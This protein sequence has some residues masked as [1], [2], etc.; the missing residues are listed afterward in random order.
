MPLFCKS[1]PYKIISL[2]EAMICDKCSLRDQ[3]LFCRECVFSCSI[4]KYTGCETCSIIY[5]CE[6]CSKDFCNRCFIDHRYRYCGT[7]N[8]EE[9]L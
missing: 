8:E 3:T 9:S 1:C 6:T 5:E 4:C 7:E 2:E